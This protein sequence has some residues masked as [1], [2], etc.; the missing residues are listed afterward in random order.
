MPCCF[1]ALLAQVFS[2]FST[3]IELMSTHYIGSLRMSCESIKTMY[4]LLVPTDLY[5]I[6]SNLTGKMLAFRAP[7]K[8]NNKVLKNACLMNKNRLGACVLVN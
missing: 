4:I 7:K 2:L 6:E 1:Y 5:R 3:Q 8:N